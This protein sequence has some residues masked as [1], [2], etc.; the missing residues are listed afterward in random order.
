MPRAALITLVCLSL[1][2]AGCGSGAASGG[3]DPASA[4]PANAAVFVDATVRPDGNLREDALAAAGKVL[5]TSDPQGKIDDLVAQLFAESE[6]PKLDYARDVKPWLGEKVA[7]WVATT[8][9]SED[10][11]GAVVAASTDEEAAQAA[12][13]RAVK[14]SEK[15]FAKRSYEDFD[16]QVSEKSAVGVVDDFVVAGTEAE[17]KRTVDAIKG[18]GLADDDRYR[19]ATDDL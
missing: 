19:K 7:L 3:D 5:R 14:G 13:D 9:D 4:V 2:A 8:N 1:A 15:S 17:F 16:Y 18:D 6:Q 11:R 10:F 12:I